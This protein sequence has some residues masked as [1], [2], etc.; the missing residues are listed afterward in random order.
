MTRRPR[1]S[2]SDSGR[3]TLNHSRPVGTSGARTVPAYGISATIYAPSYMYVARHG[4]GAPFIHVN[5]SG[6]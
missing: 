3:S 5:R 4:G 2:A 6:A 1:K